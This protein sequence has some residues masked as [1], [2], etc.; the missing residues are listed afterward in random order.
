MWT[1]SRF[2]L[3]AIN[4]LEESW[5]LMKMIPEIPSL[6]EYIKKNFPPLSK[7][8]IDPSLISISS[9][10]RLRKDLLS[11]DIEIVSC[12]KNLVDQIWVNQPSKR[13]YFL[14][15]PQT[16]ISIH[17]IQYSGKSVTVKLSNVKIRIDIS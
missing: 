5:E 7:I 14:E 17:P 4:E 12:E 6:S 10:N 3:Q 15:Y 1:D 13:E 9:F 11:R 8:G 2:F 16:P